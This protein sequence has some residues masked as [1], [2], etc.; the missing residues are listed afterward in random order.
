[1]FDR[2]IVGA[3]VEIRYLPESPTIAEVYPGAFSDGRTF[4]DVLALVAA[5]AAA[6]IAV[7]GVGLVR[8][9]RRLEGKGLASVGWVV[10]G[11]AE[12]HP[13][14]SSVKGITWMRLE[15]G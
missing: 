14:S 12:A 13:P 11:G 4:M 10:L 8:R 2:A 3:Q 6:G 5:L 7:G 1:V 15:G 9:C